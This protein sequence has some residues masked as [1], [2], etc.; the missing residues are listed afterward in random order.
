MEELPLEEKL[1][2]SFAAQEKR[3]EKAA[4]VEKLIKSYRGAAALMPK[5]KYGQPIEEIVPTFG[6]TLKSIIESENPR[7]AEFLGISTGFHK[8]MEEETRRRQEYIENFQKKTADLAF[9]NAQQKQLREQRIIRGL[10]PI[11][12]NKLI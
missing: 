6:I 9:K 3:E 10:D 8:R 7:L 2:Q 12:G 4:E 5:R 1:N 11:T